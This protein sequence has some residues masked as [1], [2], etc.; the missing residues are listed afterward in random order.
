MLSVLD[1]S[2]SSV[3]PCCCFMNSSPSEDLA[4]RTPRRFEEGRVD[5]ESSKEVV[6]VVFF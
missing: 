4:L 6:V 2:L 5:V 1:S 3:L